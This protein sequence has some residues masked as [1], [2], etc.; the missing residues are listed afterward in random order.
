MYEDYIE[1][2]N[3][4]SKDLEK[5]LYLK[6]LDELEFFLKRS[7]STSEMYTE[8]YISEI[9]LEL[10]SKKLGTSFNEVITHIAQSNML[11][12]IEIIIEEDILVQNYDNYEPFNE[13][14]TKSLYA[15]TLKEVELNSSNES[16]QG[17]K[18][19]FQLLYITKACILASDKKLIDQLPI[20]KFVYYTTSSKSSHLLNEKEII[21]FFER[22]KIKTRIAILKLFVIQINSL[23]S[24]ATSRFSKV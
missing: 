5:L 18:F 8:N 21:S 17:F 11:F 3:K 20:D 19:L 6:N 2:L 13:E 12:N 15:K 22:N 10:K 7:F 9:K 24:N 14:I 1:K 16:Q 23:I 4:Y